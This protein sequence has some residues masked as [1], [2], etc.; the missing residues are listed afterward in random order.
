MSV[1]PFI[2]LTP[3]EFISKILKRPRISEIPAH[4]ASE[5]PRVKSS[6]SSKNT[7]RSR[8]QDGTV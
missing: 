4:P 1:F 7:K 6:V 8:V 2:Y 5:H 3:E